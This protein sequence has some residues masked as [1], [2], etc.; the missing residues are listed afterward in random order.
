MGWLKGS[1][2]SIA[3]L[4]YYP[5]GTGLHSRSYYVWI[6]TRLRTSHDYDTSVQTTVV[7]HI[8]VSY[9]CQKSTFVDCTRS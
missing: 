6:L 3:I 4:Q 8:Q 5:I 7:E 1:L 9:S 2:F